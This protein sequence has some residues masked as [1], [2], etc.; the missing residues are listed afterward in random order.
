MISKRQFKLFMNLSFIAILVFAIH[1]LLFYFFRR[2]FYAPNI[3]W[4][5]PFL[6]V[7]SFLSIISVNIIFQKTKRK[8]IANAYMLTILGKIIFT[9]LFL[10]PLFI[11]NNIF[12]KEYVLQFFAIYFVYMVIE[13]VYLSK[14]VK[15][16]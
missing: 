8:N 15:S 10:L 6:F 9:L 13:L 12:K 11:N 7:L 1:Y 2:Y 14:L 5:H 16:S 3:F 4:V